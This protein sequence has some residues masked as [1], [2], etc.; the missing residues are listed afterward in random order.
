MTVPWVTTTANLCSPRRIS[1]N[2]AS[3]PQDEAHA[4]GAMGE[5]AVEALTELLRHDDAWIKINATFTLE[6]LT[7][8]RPGEDRPGLR[9][10][11][12]YLKA[13]RWDHML[14]HGKRIF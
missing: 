6:A 1:F 7:R 8:P 10:S 2:A 13:H 5:V 9:H 4:L 11:L 14:A 3:A 12:H